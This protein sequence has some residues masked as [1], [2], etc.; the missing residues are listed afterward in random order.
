MQ[1]LPNIYMNNYINNLIVGFLHIL[2]ILFLFPKR[3]GV[4][5]REYSSSIS[6]RVYMCNNW[7]FGVDKLLLKLETNKTSLSVFLKILNNSWDYPPHAPPPSLV[8]VNWTRFSSP[9][10]PRTRGWHDRVLV[11]GSGFTG[12]NCR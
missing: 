9:V 5:R 7:L 8:P 12:H 3:K 1:I 6:M 2:I 10:F 11:P 4:I